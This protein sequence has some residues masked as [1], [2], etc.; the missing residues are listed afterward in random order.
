MPTRNWRKLRLFAGLLSAS[1][2]VSYFASQWFWGI[3]RTSIPEERIVMACQMVLQLDSFLTA[4][5]LV[6]FSVYLG[7]LTQFTRNTKGTTLSPIIT[8]FGVVGIVAFAIS[9]FY[10]IAGVINPTNFNL[11]GALSSALGGI[12]IIP[13]IWL[14]MHQQFQTLHLAEQGLTTGSPR[15]FV[16]AKIM[17]RH[18]ESLPKRT[19]VGYKAEDSELQGVDEVVADQT[20]D[21]EL[22]AIFFAIQELKTRL[23]RFTIVSDNESVISEIKRPILQAKR[24][25]PLLLKIR[26]ELKSRPE[27]VVQWLGSNPAH[28]VLNQHLA[29]EKTEGEGT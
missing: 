6:G 28:R 4:G 24:P 16:D 9:A 11:V 12:M 25:R 18:D 2:L 21:A 8:L 19:F 1:V 26:E 7:R 22:H 17:G 10:A 23:E 3:F 20:D 5:F 13:V 14:G 29:K 15:V 27:I